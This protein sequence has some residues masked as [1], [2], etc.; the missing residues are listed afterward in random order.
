M[1]KVE[2]PNA[3]GM[4]IVKLDGIQ[5]AILEI[6]EIDIVN[7]TPLLDTKPFVPAYDNRAGASSEWLDK[8][9]L[10]ITKGQA[11]KHRAE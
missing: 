5:D 11:G 9:H 4:S 6:S 7:E 3:I 1:K 2:R 10:D 8:P